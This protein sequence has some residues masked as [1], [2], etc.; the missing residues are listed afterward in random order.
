MPPTTM[1]ELMIRRFPDADPKILRDFVKTE[2]E[3]L[4]VRMGFESLYALKK[5][6]R[7]N[8]LSIMATLFTLSF[9]QYSPE[10]D[11]WFFGMSED[12]QDTFTRAY[13]TELEVSP[14]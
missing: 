1:L 11:Q 7:G 6:N 8:A 12:N 2:A 9:A 10:M 4:V 3:H 13:L 14:I 5:A